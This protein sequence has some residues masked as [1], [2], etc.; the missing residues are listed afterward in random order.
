MASH[1]QRRRVHW[2]RYETPQTPF[3]ATCFKAMARQDI[4]A[5]TVDTVGVQMILVASRSTAYCPY[6][7]KGDKIGYS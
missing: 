7:T 6:M 4:Y 2:M 5:V 3:G 1:G